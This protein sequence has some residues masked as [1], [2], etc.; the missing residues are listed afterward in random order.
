MDD[1]QGYSVEDYNKRIAFQDK[2]KRFNKK[3]DKLQKSYG[4]KLKLQIV[5][6]PE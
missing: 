5:I 3:L 6:V 4:V 1:K 2:V